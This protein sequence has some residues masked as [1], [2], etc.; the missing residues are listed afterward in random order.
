MHRAARYQTFP[1]AALLA[2][3]AIGMPAGAQTP[4][5][6]PARSLGLPA[7]AATSAAAP[8][9]TVEDL[10]K[11][12]QEAANAKDWPRA[13]ELMQQAYGLQQTYDVLGNLGTAEYQLG[14]YR[15]AAEHLARS[16]HGF[17][18]VGDPGV[19]RGTEELLLKAEKEVGTIRLRVTPA[20][21]R[22]YVGTRG[23]GPED[24]REKVYVEPGDVSVSAG[25]VV[26]Y[27]AEKKQA[28]LGKGEAKEVD[29]ALQPEA[30]PV[31]TASATAVPAGGPN[32]GLLGAGIGVAAASLGVGIGLLVGGAGKKDEA[33]KLREDLL[34]GGKKVCAPDNPPAD[35]KKFTDAAGAYGTL[36][37]VGASL[38]IAAG[39]AGAATAIYYAVARPGKPTPPTKAGFVAGPQ[40]AAFAI[41]GSF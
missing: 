26:G 15:D 35:C 8:A 9:P 2:L 17:P 22:V 16:V 33:D 20:Q 40:G 39:V 34:K 21:A 30:G 28:K 31:P 4:K 29:L 37:N 32:K 13:Y 19:K 41:E 25:D 6:A 12:F 1:A 5:P 10:F 11:K 7:G 27:A 24:Y 23:Y 38:L 18:A 36:T 3:L 14:K